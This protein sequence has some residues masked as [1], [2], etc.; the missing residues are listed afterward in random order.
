MRYLYRDARV[1]AVGEIIGALNLTVT[2]EGRKTSVVASNIIVLPN[3]RRKGVGAKLVGL[4]VEDYPALTVDAVMTRL[5][6]KFFGYTETSGA[7]AE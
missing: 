7:V 2:E 5:G 1:A 4:A 3:H 6:G